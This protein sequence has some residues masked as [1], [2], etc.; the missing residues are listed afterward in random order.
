MLRINEYGKYAGNTYRGNH[1]SLQKKLSN[2]EASA[3]RYQQA[4]QG[5]DDR[6]Q[7]GLN[8]SVSFLPP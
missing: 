4:N 7:S 8:S 6:N 3:L 1:Y 5:K 2:W